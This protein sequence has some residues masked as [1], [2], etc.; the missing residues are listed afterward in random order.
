[1]QVLE[2]S[3]ADVAVTSETVSAASAKP[4]YP[5]AAPIPTQIGPEGIRFDF[6]SGARVMVPA[7]EYRTRLLDLDTANLL[8]QTDR[9][10]VT[11]NSSKHYFV[12]FKVEIRNKAGDIILSHAYD[13]CDQAVL[14]TMP[15]G[16][17]GDTVGWLPYAIRFQ[18]VHQC[19]L[20]VAL[21][22]RMIPLF[23][24]AYPHV[25]FITHEQV[26]PETFYATYNIGLFFDDAAF[27]HQPTDFRHVGL[28]RTAGYILGVDPTRGGT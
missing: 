24:G 19:R 7:G 27:A 16:T 2:S 23:A 21:A 14:I 28:H 25:R 22:E 26:V 9:G 11:V 1:M 20:T 10:G 5:N 17:I 13:A 3:S 12:R 4:P 6:N 8:F 18:D 15:I